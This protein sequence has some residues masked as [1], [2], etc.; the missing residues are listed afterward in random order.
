MSLQ[1][2]LK[3]VRNNFTAGVIFIIPI[4][5]T[6]LLIRAL[7]NIL[8]D[9]F[10]LL[11]A[12]LQPAS[13]FSFAGAEIILALAMLLIIGFLANNLIGA[14]FI[15]MGD[16]L[17]SKIPVLRTVYQAVKHLTTGIVGDKKIFRHVVLVEFPIK[18]LNFIGFVTGEDIK[19]QKPDDEK[20]YKIFIPT[21]PNPT[22]GFFCY[23]SESSVKKM[24][25]SVEEAFKLVISAGY[26]N[27]TV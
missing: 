25:I 15:K 5:V 13:Y 3:I 16:G 4:W 14:K 10:S 11:P 7:I 24:D 6:I 27:S 26:T 23:A 18:G 9:M 12:A 22:S 21:T 20:I 1:R 8:D 19:G 2:I 17:I